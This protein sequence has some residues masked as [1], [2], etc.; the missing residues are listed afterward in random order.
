MPLTPVN[1]STVASK[2]DKP[3][4]IVPLAQVA[5]LSLSLYICQGQ[6]SWHR[7]LDEDELF[8]VHEGVISLDTERGRLTLHSEELAVVPKGLGHRTSSQLRSVVVLIRPAVL[9]DRKNGQRHHALATDPPLEKVRLAR[10]QAMLVAP[11]QALPVGQVEDFE[12]LL[13]S[14]HGPGPETTAPIHGVPWLALRGSLSVAT[15]GGD[16]SPLSPGD[17]LVVPGG[18]PYRLVADQP[19]IALTLARAAPS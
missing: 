19:S 9:S 1:L 7:H 14:A 2:V 18:M 6:V 4:T 5:D 10:I 11:Y 16:V 17:L 3:F 12:L 15:L 8:L 13:L